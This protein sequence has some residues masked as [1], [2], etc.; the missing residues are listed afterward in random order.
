VKS[1]DAYALDDLK[2]IYRVLHAH[3]LDHVE[4]MDS[5]LFADLQT[6]LQEA[7]RQGGVDIGDHGKWDAWL[8]VESTPCDIRMQSRRTLR[9]PNAK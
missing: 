4:L 5:S 9:D 7:A 8:G 3:L 6:H 1:L 2:A